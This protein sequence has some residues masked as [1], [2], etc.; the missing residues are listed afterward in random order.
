MYLGSVTEFVKSTVKL[1]SMQA[2]TAEVLAD[3]S[4]KILGIAATKNTN[5]AANFGHL[6]GGYDAQYYGYM[7]SQPGRHRFV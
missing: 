3:L 5:M 2:N 7:V 6:A 1:F 4:E